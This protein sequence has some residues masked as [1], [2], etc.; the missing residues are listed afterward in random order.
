MRKVLTAILLFIGLN[1]FGQVHVPFESRPSENSI[2]VKG[3]YTFLSNSI[4][5]RYDR[6]NNANV[7]YN[8]EENNND[9]HRDYID[10]DAD[11][12]TFSS[13]AAELSL[14]DCSQIVYAGL[15]WAGNYDGEVSN[16]S[17]IPGIPRNDNT[18]NPVNAI[19][20]KVPGASAYVDVIA[21]NNPDAEGEEDHIIIDDPSLQNAPY[22]CYANVTNQI[23]SLASANGTYT[24]ANVRGTRGQS[25][26]GAAGWTMVIV[27]ENDAETNKTIT[28]FDGYAAIQANQA[29]VELTVSGFKTIENGPV[30]AKLG[31]AAVEGDRSFSGDKFLFATKNN[32]NYIEL[33][34]TL[35]PQTNFFKSNITD[36]DQIAQGLLP[37]SENTLGYDSDLFDLDNT[38]NS[39]IGNG[40]EE[41]YFK[42]ETLNDTYSAFLI[43]FGV[44]VIDPQVDLI[45]NIVYN[46]SVFTDLSMAKGEAFQLQHRMSNT[47][48]DEV[49]SMTVE[50]VVPQQFELLESDISLPSG[51][52]YTYDASSR[53]LSLTFDANTVTDQELVY[54][55][56]F[57]VTDNCSGL[58]GPCGNLVDFQMNTSYTGVV[59]P[60]LKESVSSTEI[61]N[62]SLPNYAANS[63]TLTGLEDC[64][65]PISV[66]LCDGD[67]AL[68]AA[69]GYS[70]YIW[71]FD[72]NQSGVLDASD[73]VVAS[74]TNTFSASYAGLFFVEQ[75]TD[76]PDCSNTVMSFDVSQSGFIQNNPLIPYINGDIANYNGTIYQC[77][78]TNEEIPIF[79]LCDDG[80]S[81]DF[82]LNLNGVVDYNWEKLDPNCENA[83]LCGLHENSCDWQPVT[84]SPN[85]TVSEG[86]VYRINLTQEDGCTTN[87]F[88][89]VDQLDYNP[90][91]FVE[92]HRCTTLG[93]IE[94]ANLSDQFRF[95]LID[96]ISYQILR[97]FQDSPVFEDL[98][99]GVYSVEIESNLEGNACVYYIDLIEIEEIETE[100][101]FYFNQIGCD[102]LGNAS[103]ELQN[104]IGQNTFSF[105]EGSTLI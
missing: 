88:F 81:Y 25:V 15:Y 57:Q 100:D 46:N 62:C 69:E 14:P 54:T 24:V 94:I 35:N 64:D 61:S 29:P 73:P 104:V 78:D 40:E 32:P 74:G 59:N 5:N 39:I 77:E 96:P 41:A 93:S 43:A 2:K 44:E 68:I 45:Q 9:L 18:R 38:N 48:N 50:G 87:Y 30:A 16:N 65:A 92:D 21:D 76:D 95:R 101:T 89:R 86:G 17:M 91:V 13:S 63:I 98:T 66:D 10:V 52:N 90:E 7:A 84:N 82:N 20:L 34:N 102:D 80:S 99:E 6:D 103:L 56:P 19:K 31:V 60:A 36:N 51:I 83:D 49:G 37:S 27:Y 72:Q 58:M 1:T 4:L 12:S 71:K 75:I 53:L 23:Q 22:V 3:N 8:G 67:A 26:G 47:G 70:D 55:L 42:L 33:G 11:E 85:Y 28:F 105:F 79:Y 97:D